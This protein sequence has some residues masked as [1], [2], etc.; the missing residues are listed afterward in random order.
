MDI[1]SFDG[2]SIARAIELIAALLTVVWIL[3]NLTGVY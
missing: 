3:L 2:P 1:P